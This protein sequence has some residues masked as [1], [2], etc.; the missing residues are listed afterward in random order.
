MEKSRP[1]KIRNYRR[2]FLNPGLD[3]LTEGELQTRPGNDFIHGLYGRETVTK[4]IQVM[5]TRLRHAVHGLDL[6]YECLEHPDPDHLAES[7]ACML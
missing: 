3:G 1:L 6:R 5:E 4:D 2:I 7:P